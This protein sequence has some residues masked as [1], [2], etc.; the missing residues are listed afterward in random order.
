MPS[1]LRRPVS[2]SVW[3]ALATAALFIMPTPRATTMPGGYPGGMPANLMALRREHAAVAEA[4]RRERAMLAEE[5]NRLQQAALSL[6]EE[7]ASLRR[8]A[9]AVVEAAEG[10]LAR[11]MQQVEN[12]R[13][14][15]EA[16]EQSIKTALRGEADR[17]AQERRRLNAEA[18]GLQAERQSLMQAAGL[19][20][21]ERVRRL[22]SFNGGEGEQAAATVHRERATLEQ[23]RMELEQQ[24]RALA[25]ERK[26]LVRETKV[27]D[28]E[29]NALLSQ[30][31]QA[32]RDASSGGG[33]MEQA[34]AALQRER[35]ALEQERAELETRAER[36]LQERQTLDRQAEAMQAADG[37]QGDSE[38]LRAELAGAKDRLARQVAEFENYRSRTE[39]QEKKRVRQ[40][41]A[42]AA[43]PLISVLDD[44]RRASAN[45]DKAVKEALAPLQ[46]KLLAVLETEIK[47]RPMPSVVGETFNPE[48]H[49]AIGISHGDAPPDTILQEVEGGFV[50]TDG[51]GAYGDKIRPAKVVVCVGPEA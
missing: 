19:Q 37:S 25:E 7:R 20:E 44:F 4:L 51:A 16:E 26:R 40:L 5:R 49:E 21:A 23:V 18:A 36:L 24:A 11:Q 6:S 12:Y 1:R 43:R 32:R 48:L 8:Q 33:R 10:R 27:L 34:A 15:T 22:G 2:A 45:A 35:T 47:V 29:R 14:Q 30:A 39:A 9:S 38:Q 3:V 31:E 41:L 42:K 13:A 17:L 28:S 46:R 50:S